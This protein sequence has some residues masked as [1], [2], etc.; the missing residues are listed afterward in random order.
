MFSFFN[1]ISI[2]HKLIFTFSFFALLVGLFVFFFFPYQQKKQILRQAT[3]KSIAITKMT[4]DNMTASLEFMD[5]ATARDVLNVLKDNEDFVFVV[6][7]DAAGKPFASINQSQALQY[8]FSATVKTPTSRIVDNITITTLPVLSQEN[9]IGTIVVGLSIARIREELTWNTTVA[10]LV[11]IVLVLI[12]VFAAVIISNVITQPI[13]NIIEVSSDIARGDFTSKLMVTSQ[14]EVGKLA[15]AFNEMSDK[16]EESTNQR[17]RYEEELLKSHDE[18]EMRVEERT[19]QLMQAKE[20]AEAA[21]RAKS[22][23]LANMSHEL[24]TPLNHIIGFTELVV[25][26]KFGDLNEDQEEY[27]DDALKSSRHLLSLIND[28]LDLSKVEAGKFEL[29]PTEVDPRLLL[30]NCL[31]MFKEKAM[32]H[33]IQLLSEVDHIPET[34]RADERKLKQIVYNILANAMKFTPDGGTVSLSAQKV[35]CIIRPGQRWDDAAELRVIEC[36]ID[37]GETTDG[38]CRKC[39]KFSVSDTGIGIKKEDQDRI[40]APFEQADGSSSRRYQGTGL[41]LPLTRKLVELHGG[42]MWVESEGEGHGSTFSFTIP[43]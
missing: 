33:S 9:K 38:Q 25:D 20:S 21:N 10:L 43:V 5:T 31:I 30:D 27:L 41:G 1:N 39:V 28:I 8:G 4:A 11:S 40:F 36:Q 34:I 13:K 26:K 37:D 3:E 7:S 6:V 19:S 12:L 35:D 16:L 15:G 22:D 14:D 32:N 23:F 18:L 17:K 24:R 42:Q 2:K 29:E